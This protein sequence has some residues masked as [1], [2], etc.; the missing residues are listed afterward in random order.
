MIVYKIKVTSINLVILRT[1]L[2]MAHL[3]TQ[4]YNV[5]KYINKLQIKLEI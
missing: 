5:Y 1:V 3:F 2:A 4:I